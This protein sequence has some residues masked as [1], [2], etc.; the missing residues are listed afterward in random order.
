[1]I[2]APPLLAGA[3]KETV[4]VVCPVAVATKLVGAP[5]TVRGIAVAVAPG[6]IPIPL[7]G[8]TVNVY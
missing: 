7:L 6:P 8:V 4:A 3:V 2:V 5:G 1:M